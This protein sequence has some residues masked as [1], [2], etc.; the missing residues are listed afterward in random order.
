MNIRASIRRFSAEAAREYHEARAGRILIVEPSGRKLPPIPLV[1]ERGVP[2]AG[3][4]Q[5]IADEMARAHADGAAQS[6]VEALIFDIRERGGIALRDP[7][8]HR[9]IADLNE[10]QLAEVAS[11]LA[12]RCKAKPAGVASHVI[13]QFAA[14]ARR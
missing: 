7:S 9:R 1:A 11:R 14:V 5:A 13:A 6:T 2:S 4:M 12:K 3:Q 8:N 10:R